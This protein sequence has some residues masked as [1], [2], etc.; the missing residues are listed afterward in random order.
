MRVYTCLFYWRAHH[1]L[2]KYYVNGIDHRSNSH[3]ENCSNLS[4]R[5]LLHH[6]GRHLPLTLQ[7][8][9]VVHHWDL[10]L[11]SNDD[12]ADFKLSSRDYMRGVSWE[13]GV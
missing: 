13:R 4:Y 3:W 1:A 7:T 12:K 6:H 11:I 8:S 9:L 10:S 2:C 5:F